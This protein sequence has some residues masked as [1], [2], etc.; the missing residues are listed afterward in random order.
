MQLKILEEIIEELRIP[1]KDEE[2][3]DSYTTIGIG[4]PCIKMLF[5]REEKQ[6]I[7][8]LKYLEKTHIPYFILGGGSNLL[9]GDKGYEGIIIHFPSYKGFEIEKEN[10]NEVV[11]K[12]KAGTKVS[13]ILTYSV[14]EGLSGFEFL[15]GLPATVG[16]II[17]MNAGAFGKSVSEIVKEITLYFKGKTFKI[18][19]T[20]ELWNYREFKKEGIVLSASFKLKIDTPYGVKERIK[21]YIKKRKETQPISKKTFGSVFKNPPGNYAGKLIDLCGLKGYQI[22]DAQ[23]SKKHANFIVN[24]GKAK[25]EEVLE[26]IKLAQKKVYEKFK[27]QLEP[28]VKFL[29]CGI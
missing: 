25:A 3:I 26:L 19:S 10:K 1:F 20:P 22:G 24:L 14:K 12:A 18:K 15:A 27:I 2:R 7:K 11:L 29:G 9:A 6:L 23:I 13:E 8:I 5:P 28:E 4:G 16:G 17:K 21:N